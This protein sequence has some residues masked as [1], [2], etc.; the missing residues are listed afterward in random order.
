MVEQA[1]CRAPAEQKRLVAAQQVL[2]GRSPSARQTTRL[3]IALQVLVGISGVGFRL[4]FKKKKK[5]FLS[6][7]I[8]FCIFKNK[9]R[10]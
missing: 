3:A 10:K 7:S 5:T 2:G 6:N 1:V 8:F 4:I 9:A